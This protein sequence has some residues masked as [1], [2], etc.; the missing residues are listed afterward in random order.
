MFGVLKCIVAASVR[1]KCAARLLG[2]R[3]RRLSLHV[4]TEV[5]L[6]SA[7]QDRCSSVCSARP[8][9]GF[10]LKCQTEAWHQ[11]YRVDRGT[12]AE[13]Q[14]S[15][16]NASKASVRRSGPIRLTAASVLLRKRNRAV[17]ISPFAGGGV[18]L[19]PRRALAQCACA[20]SPAASGVPGS[21]RGPHA[22]AKSA[23]QGVGP[24]MRCRR[25]PGAA[26]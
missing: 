15:G 25:A 6:R 22:T 1:Y 24:R 2:S 19:A 23:G 4:Q 21:L 5:S 16:A 20:A 10:D 18:S 3:L 14:F 9:T 8:K 11:S 12:R 13:G 26:R 17:C 7:D